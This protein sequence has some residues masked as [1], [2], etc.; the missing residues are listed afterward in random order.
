MESYK[1]ECK[2]NKKNVETTGTI[3]LP[4]EA[5][6]G[7][8][9]HGPAS[10]PPGSHPAHRQCPSPFTDSSLERVLEKQFKTFRIHLTL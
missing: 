9:S 10:S 7:T 8:I 4:R 5:V 3:S 6:R 2:E 1:M